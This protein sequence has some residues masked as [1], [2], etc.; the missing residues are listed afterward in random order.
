M[1]LIRNCSH[2]PRNFNYSDGVHIVVRTLCEQ[3]GDENLDLSL[4]V[5]YEFVEVNDTTD[6]WQ[7]G[8][9]YRR[10]AH[11]HSLRMVCPCSASP[12]CFINSCYPYKHCLLNIQLLIGN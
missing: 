11:D 1:I 4:G 9:A 6:T 3:L 12:S 10:W 2:I 5:L 8:S 7:E